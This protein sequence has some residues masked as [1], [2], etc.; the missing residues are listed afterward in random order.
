MKDKAQARSII[1]RL[2]NAFK[3]NDVKEL[4]F[5]VEAMWKEGEQSSISYFLS[6]AGDTARQVQIL[7]DILASKTKGDDQVPKY[8]S[9]NGKA[10]RRADGGGRQ[11][12]NGGSQIGKKDDICD[13][14]LDGGRGVGR[15]GDYERDDANKR[16]LK[17]ERRK[18]WS[19][20]CL[21]PACNFVSMIEDCPSTPQGHKQSVLDE[22]LVKFK[23]K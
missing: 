20:S 9:R 21:H 18:N 11:G 4:L 23:L 3:P 22:H 6:C 16:R 7:D 15:K 1:K 5:R 2:P 13:G 8:L 10:G 12:R 14:D 17:E 19:K